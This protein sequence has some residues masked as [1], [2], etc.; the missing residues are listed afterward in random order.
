MCMQ[1]LGHDQSRL[2]AYRRAPIDSI[3]LKDHAKQTE[4]L[5]D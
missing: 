5:R 3:G 2:R 4:G 1:G